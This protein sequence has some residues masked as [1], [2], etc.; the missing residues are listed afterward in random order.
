MKKLLIV[1]AIFF[2]CMSSFAEKAPKKNPSD[3]VSLIYKL[4]EK[5][6]KKKTKTKAQIKSAAENLRSKELIFEKCKFTMDPIIDDRQNKE[7]I[8]HKWSAPLRVQ[9]VDAWLAEAKDD[10]FDK[11]LLNSAPT[12]RDVHLKASLTRLYSYAQNLNIHG[13]SALR[14]DIYSQGEKITTK[15]YRGLG[16]RV[17]WVNGVPEYHSAVTLAMR[18]NMQVLM[19]DLS[20]ICELATNP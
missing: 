6:K 18:D 12:A 11:K 7:T 17:N 4:D 1:S 15:R 14:I 16:S 8:G 19:D 13:V 3:P 5:K 20:S 2:S 10:L 9:G